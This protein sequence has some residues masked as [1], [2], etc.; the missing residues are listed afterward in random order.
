MVDQILLAWATPVNTGSLGASLEA[1]VDSQPVINV[2]NLYVKYGQI[3]GA[4]IG[5]FPQELVDRVAKDI[6]EPLFCNA[7]S[8]W[9]KYQ[10]FFDNVCTPSDHFS[11]SELVSL[12]AKEAR[13]GLLV[14]LVIQTTPMRVI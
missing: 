14:K 8:R 12:R 5:K 3:S 4:P 2:L 7:A 1:Y 9:A 11:E 13:L 10:F 6:Y